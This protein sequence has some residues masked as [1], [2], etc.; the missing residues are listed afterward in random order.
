MSKQELRSAFTPHERVG[1]QDWGEDLTKQEFKEECDI[2]KI[3]AK[4]MKDRM[5]AHVEEYGG[6]YEDVT[7]AVD[8]QEAHEIVQKAEEMFSTVPAEVRKRFENN[9]EL[10]LNF[11]LDPKNRE[12]V[13]KMGLGTLPEPTQL[14]LEQAIEKMV[15]KV[16]QDSEAAEAAG[17]STDT[18]S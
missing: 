8:L 10:F 3:M 17:D 14:D 15:D 6:R 5:A 2:N 4:Y 9:P 11:V 18:R 16:V 13:E 1:I 7:G 12:D